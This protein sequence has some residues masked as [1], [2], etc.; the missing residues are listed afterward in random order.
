M[1]I[2]S[3]FFFTKKNHAIYKNYILKCIILNINYKTKLY[4]ILI[5]KKERIRI[6]NIEYINIIIIGNNKIINKNGLV[7]DVTRR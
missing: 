1:Y 6:I 3:T 7:R 5:R 4:Q 2:L